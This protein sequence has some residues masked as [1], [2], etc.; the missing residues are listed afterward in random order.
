MKERKLKKTLQK[1]NLDEPSDAFTDRI[2][3][4]IATIENLSLEPAIAE[5]V[6]K[7]VATDPSED[8]TSQIM[9]QL[10]PKRR[11]VI[12]PVISRKAW[13]W[14]AGVVSL[15]LLVAIMSSRKGQITSPDTNAVID[16]SVRLIGMYSQQ[17][18]LFLIVICSLLLGDY[19]VR[20]KWSPAVE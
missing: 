19:F 17:W 16:S 5:I 2:M 1:M 10:T 13:L 20:R 6:K 15:I 7:N 4:Q 3:S 18:I 8:F 12:E 9:A 14:I 11:V